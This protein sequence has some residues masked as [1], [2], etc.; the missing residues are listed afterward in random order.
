M[1]EGFLPGC[2]VVVDGEANNVEGGVLRHDLLE[3]WNFCAAGRAPRGPELYERV[4]L[5]REHVVQL[6]GLAICGGEVGVG[7]DGAE[8]HVFLRRHLLYQ[9]IITCFTLPRGLQDLEDLVH[10][11][12]CQLIR[13]DEYAGLIQRDDGGGVFAD[14]VQAGIVALLAEGFYF[15]LHAD[16][17]GDDAVGALLSGVVHGGLFLAELAQAVL[18]VGHL[19][20]ELLVQLLRG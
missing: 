10:V 20:V 19:G 15:A 18:L 7:D 14:K 2:V 16:G 1:I 17:L 5:F 3:M 12:R 13:V 9:Q 11:R 6:D 8:S 4:T